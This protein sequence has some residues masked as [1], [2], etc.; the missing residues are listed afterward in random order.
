MSRANNHGPKPCIC[1][2]RAGASWSLT[3]TSSKSGQ[4]GNVVRRGVVPSVTGWCVGGMAWS[5]PAKEPPR[6]IAVGRGGKNRP[7]CSYDDGSRNAW[8][9]SGPRIRP[10]IDCSAGWRLYS[11]RGRYACIDVPLCV[12]N[13]LFMNRS[14]DRDIDTACVEGRQPQRGLAVVQQARAICIYRYNL[15][16]SL[17]MY[18]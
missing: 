8:I 6:K 11:R 17:F 18:L 9:L 2:E 1:A 7:E 15:C 12:F 5:P 4:Y 3:T 13:Y 16:V 10:L 14:I